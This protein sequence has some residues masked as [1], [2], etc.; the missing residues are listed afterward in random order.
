[1]RSRTRRSP[2]GRR[3][4]VGW[5]VGRID[6]AAIANVR[7]RPAR[8]ARS[9]R[10]H[11]FDDGRRAGRDADVR[12]AA[13]P[14]AKREFLLRIGAR[15]PRARQSFTLDEAADSDRRGPCRHRDCQL[16]ASAR[17]TISARSR[18]FPTSATITAWSSAPEI[19][20]W[21]IERLRTLA[22]RDSDRRR[23]GRHA[24]RPATAG[25]RDR[26]GALPVRAD[27]ASAAS[28]CRRA[29]GSRRGAV[30]G[31]HRVRPG[32]SVEARF[33]DASVGRL[34]TRCGSPNRGEAGRG[35][36]AAAR[37]MADG[38]DEPWVKRPE[39]SEPRR[40]KGRPLS[41]GDRAR[42]LFAATAINYIDRQMIGVLKPIICSKR[43]PLDERDLCRHRR[44][45]PGR[46]CDRLSRLRQGGRRDRRA[47]RLCRRGRD[48]DDRPRRP[49]RRRIRVTQFALARFGLGIGESGNFP[50]GIK[51][52][53]RMVSAE[54]ARL[55]DRPVQRRLQCRRDRRRRCSCLLITLA[56]G[57]R[58]AFIVTGMFGRGLAGRLA[59][60]SIATRASTSSVGAA[61]LA[62][63]SQ[64]P[65][66]PASSATGL[67]LQPARPARDL[68]VRA[69]QVLH[70]SDLV[71]LPVLAART[72]LGKQ[73]HLDLKTAS[74][75]PLRRRSI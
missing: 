68:G 21:R 40:R 56:Y 51:A 41:L 10:A 11:V 54:G 18:S 5:K 74:A 35:L 45:V 17:S 24:A 13:S 36:S 20:D 2:H 26:R 3:P 64:D 19:P 27:G 63:I 71:V 14:P 29:S 60:R 15:R 59:R 1:M 16:A 57:W 39:H 61:E 34:Q 42:L 52:V 31:V 73:L 12:R 67:W 28:R 7:R 33:G 69:R 9:S 53:D 23:R 25:R 75:P 66:D 55:R 37:R 4:V 44:L 58:M 72:I 22:G 32:Q 48:L 38:G 6:A 47:A 49:W 70:R 30:T 46:L 8:P 65:A 62:Y 43:I 50:A